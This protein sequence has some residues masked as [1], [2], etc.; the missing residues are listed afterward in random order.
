MPCGP[1]PYA[2]TMG[3]LDRLTAL[4]KDFKNR[5]AGE[6]ADFTGAKAELV[7][8]LCGHSHVDSDA[9]EDN[10]LFVSTSS[11]ACLQDDVWK[12]EWG[13]ASEELLDL[14]LLD[15]TARRLDAIRLGAGESRTFRY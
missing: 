13:K 2:E 8:Y 12:R 7:A 9:V 11:S 3:G 1:L 4:L 15:R 10:V 14:F 6:L 5:R